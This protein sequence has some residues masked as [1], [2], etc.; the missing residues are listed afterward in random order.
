MAAAVVDFD[1]SGFD[2]DSAD[3]NVDFDADADDIGYL[4]VHHTLVLA[5]LNLLLHRQHQHHHKR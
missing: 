1:V 4:V 3:G 2:V 5:H